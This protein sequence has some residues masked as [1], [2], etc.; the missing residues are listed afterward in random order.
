MIFVDVVSS[1]D[2]LKLQNMLVMYL[3]QQIDLNNS[4]RRAFHPHMTVAFKDLKPSIF[5]DAWDYFQRQSFERDFEADQLFLLKHDG[6]KWQV[7]QTIRLL[8]N[9]NNNL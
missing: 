6:S 8:K 1:E 3:K 5:P 4:D 9:L 2:L 7:I